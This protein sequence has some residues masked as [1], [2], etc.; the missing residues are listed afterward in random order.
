MSF[1]ASKIVGYDETISV[2]KKVSRKADYYVSEVLNRTKSKLK[3]LM[4]EA[5]TKPGTLM[6]RVNENTLILRVFSD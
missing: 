3:K 1:K 4:D 6:D 5:K 2:T